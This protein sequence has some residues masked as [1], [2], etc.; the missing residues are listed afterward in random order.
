MDGTSIVASMRKK[1]QDDLEV[2]IHNAAVEIL[3]TQ[4]AIAHELEIAKA[5]YPAY[6]DEF[7]NK[8]NVIAD[9]ASE[10]ISEVKGASDVAVEQIANGQPISDAIFFHI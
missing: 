4:Q 9:A 3:S 7:E 6:A 1:S 10:A 5:S 8:I 2:L